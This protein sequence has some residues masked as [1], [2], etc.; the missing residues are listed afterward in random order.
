MNNLKS[1]I[2]RL[3][4]RFG[5]TLGD[6]ILLCSI[7]FFALLSFPLMP[8]WIVSE[9]KVLEIRAGDKLV[10]RYSLNINKVV[11]VPG[12]LGTTSV[13]IE[14]GRARILSSPCPHK[15]CCRMGDIGNE[16]G[17]LVCVPNEVIVAITGE[18]AE[19]LDA[20]SR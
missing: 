16:G 18:Q 17:L 19:D 2:N 10:G 5:M 8:R 11:K 15:I 20:V 12:R 3:R 4:T 14:N 13:L 6:G 9:G 7:I 1:K